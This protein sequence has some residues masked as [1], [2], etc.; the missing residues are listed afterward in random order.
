M[1]LCEKGLKPDENTLLL[2][3]YFWDP[4]VLTSLVGKR[5]KQ[6]IL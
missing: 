4:M 5:F 3:H 1:F 2:W 6:D